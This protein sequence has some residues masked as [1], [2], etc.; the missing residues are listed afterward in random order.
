LLRAIT[1]D[2]NIKQGLF[3]GPGV[4]VSTARGGGKLKSDHH[5]AV[6][7][8]L[9]SQ[10]LDYKECFDEAQE[11][12]AKAKK[13]W[14]NKI[15]NKLWKMT[16]VTKDINKTMGQTGE[17]ITSED[18]IKEGT[19]IVNKWEVI[20]VECPWYF[21]MKAFIAE[22]PNVTPTGLSN[23]TSEIDMEDGAQSSAIDA[24]SD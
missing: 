23:S 4:N 16:L 13:P 19:E 24:E 8:E 2:T 10:H 20:R 11:G 21:D 9:F 6:C 22:H 3:P 14:S 17:G 15:K 7:V 1:D 12:P 18:Q 5:W